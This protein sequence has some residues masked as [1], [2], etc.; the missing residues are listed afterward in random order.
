MKLKEGIAM[1]DKFMK[2]KVK[3]RME[4][5]NPDYIRDFTDSLIKTSRDEK[6]FKNISAGQKRTV[7]NLDLLLFDMIIAGNTLRLHLLSYL[8]TGWGWVRS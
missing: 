8:Q 1:R 6:A 2:Q 5:F 4:T 7:E 3:E